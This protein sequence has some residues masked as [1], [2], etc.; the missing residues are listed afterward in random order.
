VFSSGTVWKKQSTNG[1]GE[2][3]V[4]TGEQEESKSLIPP[5]LSKTP[6]KDTPT[7]LTSISPIF[8]NTPEEKSLVTVSYLH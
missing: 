3:T 7:D 2:Q 4:G 8:P 5:D 1:T 6:L